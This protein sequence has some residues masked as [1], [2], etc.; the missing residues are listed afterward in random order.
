MGA[1]ATSRTQSEWPAKDVSSFHPF[2]E[3]CQI[4]IK[5]SHPAEANLFAVA[6]GTGVE[7]ILIKDPGTE[8][9]AQE[10]E[11]TPIECA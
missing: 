4:F 7:D 2:S 11:F 9:G 3:K 1:Q 5:L 10:T 8:E 6:E